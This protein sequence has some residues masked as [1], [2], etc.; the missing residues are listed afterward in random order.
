MLLKLRLHE[1]SQRDEPLARVGNQPLSMTQ[2][3]MLSGV[4]ERFLRQNPKLK[5]LPRELKPVAEAFPRLPEEAQNATAYARRLHELSQR[6]EEPLARLDNQ[7]LSTAQLAQLSGV[8][9]WNLKKALG[10]T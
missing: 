3:A 6:G 2:L 4:P 7:P 10:L 5:P 9:E 8:P 1:L